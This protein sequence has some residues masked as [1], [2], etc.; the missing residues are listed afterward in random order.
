M[1][2]YI[3]MENIRIRNC[4][5]ANYRFVHRLSKR[6][7]EEYVKKYWGKWDSRKFKANFKKENIKIINYNKRKIGFFEVTRKG[8]ITYLNNIQIIDFFQG[9]GIGKNMIALI[10]T[11]EKKAGIKKVQLQ[12]FKKNPAKLFYRKLGYNIVKSSAHSVIMEK[13]L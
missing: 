2:E 3:S 12:V 7:M 8:L 6:N 9:K 4:A 13:V 10:E 5:T 11:G 1:K